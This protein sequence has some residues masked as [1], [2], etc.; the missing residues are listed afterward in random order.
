MDNKGDR[1][2][3]LALIVIGSLSTLTFLG[4]MIFGDEDSSFFTMNLVFLVSGLSLL[5]GGLGIYDIGVPGKNKEEE[6]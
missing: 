2:T 1:K 3:N 5:A 6:K 4:W